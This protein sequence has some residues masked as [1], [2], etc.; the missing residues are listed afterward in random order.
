[1]RA[2]PRETQHGLLKGE[3]TT[4]SPVRFGIWD[5]GM[6]WSHDS[7]RATKRCFS[8]TAVRAK[9]SDN[10]RLVTGKRPWEFS[11]DLIPD[12]LDRL[13]LSGLSRLDICLRDRSEAPGRRRRCRRC[14]WQERPVLESP[15][16]G[17]RL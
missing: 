7:V 2:L 1:M 9:V 10:V 4:L 11:W 12:C 14:G 16:G 17:M 8:R 5:K 6:V 15:R 13:G 3:E